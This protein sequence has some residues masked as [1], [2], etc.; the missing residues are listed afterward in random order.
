M[1]TAL[2]MAIGLAAVF[3]AV[4][5]SFAQDSSVLDPGKPAGTATKA[6]ERQQTHQQ[7]GRNASISLAVPTG[8]ISVDRG[9]AGGAPVYTR[10]TTVGP[11]ITVVEVST[12]PFEPVP[13]ATG[14]VHA[15]VV[16]PDQPAGW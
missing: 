3:G 1:R 13:A 10:R 9:A 11:G 16:R 14:T 4:P 5:A 8:R 12:T 7:P 15:A 6:K 2:C